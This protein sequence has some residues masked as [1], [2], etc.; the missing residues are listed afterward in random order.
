MKKEK[1]SVDALI[2][3]VANGG[4]VKTGIDIFN[5]NDVLV[6]EKDVPVNDVNILLI[7]KENGVLEIP[8]IQDENCGVWD[9]SGSKIELKSLKIFWGTFKN[10][11]I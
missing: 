8:I 2:E 5:E 7:L 10:K 4:S 9:R 6:L 1:I 11:T 3:I